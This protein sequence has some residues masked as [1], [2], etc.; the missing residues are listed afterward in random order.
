[1]KNIFPIKKDGEKN[2]YNIPNNFVN[3]FMN[4]NIST[5]SIDFELEEH[6]NTWSF[7]IHIPEKD[8][9]RKQLNIDHTIDNTDYIS[10]S[11]DNSP[12]IVDIPL[13]L[14]KIS[15]T[16]SIK[17]RLI[18]FGK[19]FDKN[20]VKVYADNIDK[21]RIIRNAFLESMQIFIPNIDRITTDTESGEV[22]IEETTS[23]KA[24]PLH[25]YG[26][27]AKKLFRIL[28]QITLQKDGKLLIDE[29]DAGIHYSHF[30]DFWKVVLLVAK[31][32]NVQIF[33][34]THNIECVEYF[35]DVL[36][37]ELIE[38]QN[39]SRVISLQKLSKSTTKAYTHTFKEFEYELDNEFE[40]R[41]GD[42]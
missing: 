25:Q 31:E 1:M 6:R 30:F 15:S 5:K 26:E 39:L 11:I 33:A 40:I 27:G 2:I 37:E 13:L 23:D 36:E 24:S 29:I 19:G 38:Y 8:E 42:L 12:Y 21:N 32:N 16:D 34:T 3:D 17:T 35:K 20:L 22:Y 10:L 41:G 14:E 28:V 7:K 4:K 9:V 18:P